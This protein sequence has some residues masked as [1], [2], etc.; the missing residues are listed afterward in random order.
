MISLPL[1]VRRDLGEGHVDAFIQQTLYMPMN[2]LGQVVPKLG[3]E[4]QRRRLSNASDA[5]KGGAKF[6]GTWT[7][8]VSGEGDPVTASRH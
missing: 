7:V 2:V 1:E 6:G 5:F 4:V 3:R 8:Q